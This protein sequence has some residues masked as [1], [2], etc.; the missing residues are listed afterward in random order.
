MECVNTAW[1]QHAAELR[2][3]L[4]HRLN[5][6]QDVD[7]LMQDVFLKALRQ[8]SMFCE[9]KNTR[10]WLFA[11]ARN[12]LIDRF[13]SIQP[14]M[15]KLPDDIPAENTDMEAVDQLTACLPRVLSEL[16]PTDR[17][18]ITLCDLQGMSQADYAAHA[19][20]QLSAAKS[21]LQRARKKMHD[22]MAQVCQVTLNANGH[23]SDF[24]PRPVLE[25]P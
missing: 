11:V 22:H 20:L 5:H 19:G 9:V 24:V 3:W 6:A 4:R 16:C 8:G 10:A 21:R 12:A 2:A 25:S 17:E 18:A 13:K 1:K 15:L 23:V 7:D 14:Q